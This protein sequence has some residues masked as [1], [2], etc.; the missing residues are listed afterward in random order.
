MDAALSVCPQITREWGT[1]NGLLLTRTERLLHQYLNP[2]IEE[3][4]QRE[5]DMSP[6][7]TWH[8]HELTTL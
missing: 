1:R 3:H 5:R 2:H 7:K 6:H 4:R 8:G